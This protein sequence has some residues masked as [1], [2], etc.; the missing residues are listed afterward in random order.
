MLARQ[1]IFESVECLICKE[2]GVVHKCKKLAKH[3]ISKHQMNSEQY[4][5]LYHVKTNISSISKNQS[6]KNKQN[7]EKGSY[8]AL[9]F[10]NDMNDGEKNLVR[11]L[12]N[13][14]M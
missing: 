10:R 6:E 11:F 5:N 3:L 14:Y 13:L 9:C 1:E 4:R 12:I 2:H 8:N 7:W